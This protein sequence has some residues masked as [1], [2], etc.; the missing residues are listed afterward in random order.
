MLIS[1]PED[2]AVSAIGGACPERAETSPK[3]RIET[4]NV[5]SVLLCKPRCQSRTVSSFH[6]SRSPNSELIRLIHAHTLAAGGVKRG[7]GKPPRY[8]SLKHAVQTAIYQT[9]RK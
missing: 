3:S 6:G 4:G 9:W 1:R 8:D 2:D 7:T 5:D